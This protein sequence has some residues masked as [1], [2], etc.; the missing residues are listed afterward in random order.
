MYGSRQTFVVL[1]SIIGIIAAA[2][3]KAQTI[4]PNDVA[5]CTLLNDPSA[6][7]SCLESARHRQPASNFDPSSTQAKDRSQQLQIIDQTGIGRTEAKQSPA[8]SQQAGKKKNER[9]SSLPEEIP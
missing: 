3:V 4:A 9:K 1:A 5:A 7:R 2:H 8:A 6:Q